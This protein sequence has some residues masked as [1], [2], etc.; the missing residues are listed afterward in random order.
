MQEIYTITPLWAMRLRTRSLINWPMGS[1]PRY[2]IVVRGEFSDAVRAQFSDVG[3]SMVTGNTH[4]LTEELDQAGLYGMIG[5]L[6]ALAFVMLSMA[7]VDLG[8]VG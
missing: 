7:P 8:D 6:E 1:M 4:L 5:R 3:I 2:E